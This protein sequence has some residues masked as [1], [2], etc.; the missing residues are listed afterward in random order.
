MQNSQNL[1]KILLSDGKHYSHKLIMLLKEGCH[2][3][4]IAFV[5]NTKANQMKPK[6]KIPIYYPQSLTN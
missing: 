6:G 3:V 1:Y 4:V 5:C 2:F